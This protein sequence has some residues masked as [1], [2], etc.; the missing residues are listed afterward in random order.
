MSRGFEPDP[1]EQRRQSEANL[2]LLRVALALIDDARRLG[3]FETDEETLAARTAELTDELGSG[4]PA[5]SSP[6][7]A[8]VR[9][10][11]LALDQV[12]LS[13]PYG[14]SSSVVATLRTD[15][16]LLDE[17]VTLSLRAERVDEPGLSPEE[18][19]EMR[20]AVAEFQAKQAR[21]QFGG[22]RFVRA[23][24]ADPQ[25]GSEVQV[26]AAEL[27][28]DGLL[29]HYSFDQESESL[30]SIMS[31]DLSEWQERGPGLRVEDDLGTEYYASGG[32]GG[33]GVQVVHGAFGFAP[34]VPSNARTLRISTRGDTIELPL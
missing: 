2:L 12:Q 27:F 25:P 7:E 16:V 20:R 3:A 9:A 31:S 30:E 11:P 5:G 19:E 14:D 32:G 8:P 6:D 1:E 4:A 17:G 22:G 29:V 21:P 26:L 13:A 15:G 28:D 24:A 23:L 33:G 18:A 34:A 10:A